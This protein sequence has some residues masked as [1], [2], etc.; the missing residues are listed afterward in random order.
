VRF[1]GASI[2]RHKAFTL[3]Q[4][5][6]VTALAGITLTE[7]AADDTTA[8]LQIQYVSAAE[9]L[10]QNQPCFTNFSV[11]DNAIVAATIKANDQRVWH[12]MLHETMHLMG[13]LGHPLYNS[14]LT[15]FARGSQLTAVDKLL[16]Q[17]IYS[18]A[19][20]S[21]AS[22]FAAL[23]TLAQRMIDS[24]PEA[25]K[26]A[27]R[28]SADAFLRKTIKEME[29]F[30]SGAG[31][32]PTVIVRSGKATK[33]GIERGQIDIQYFLGLAYLRGHIVKPD[34]EKARAWLEKAAAASHGGAAAAL[35]LAAAEKS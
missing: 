11:R 3:Q 22:P 7:A 26:N 29:A 1:T 20:T 15:Y 21:G 17:T 31:E 27:T 12:C 8:N 18:D 10:P 35:K 34:K 19:V 33:Q 4:L 23:E 13:F 14:V 9:P 24:A 5:R 32:A 25:D 28:Q 30:G 16:L 6:A 2:E